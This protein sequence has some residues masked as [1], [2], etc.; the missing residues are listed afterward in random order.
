[1]GGSLCGATLCELVAASGEAMLAGGPAAAMGAG[2]AA[3]LT[4]SLDE[5]NLLQRRA[6]VRCTRLPPRM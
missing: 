1:M 3:E 2:A 5:A 4:A 6:E